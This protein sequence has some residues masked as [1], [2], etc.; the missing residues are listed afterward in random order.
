MKPKFYRYILL[1]NRVTIND[2]MAV[3]NNKAEI[4][5]IRDY[6]RKQIMLLNVNPVIYDRIE[7]I[8]IP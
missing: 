8:F 6:W 5:K 1:K 7:K 3:S 2:I 4:K